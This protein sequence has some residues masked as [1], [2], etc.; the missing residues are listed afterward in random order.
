MVCV[1]QMNHAL[2]G[3]QCSCERK[4]EYRHDAAG[5]AVAVIVAVFQK[6]IPQACRENKV[7]AGRKKQKKKTV[8]DYQFHK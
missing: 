5:V 3:S 2:T 7:Y 4:L 1:T 8:S 6:H